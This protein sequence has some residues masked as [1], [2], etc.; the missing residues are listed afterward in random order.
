MAKKLTLDD[1]KIQSFVTTLTK[2][3]SDDLIGGSTLHS[4]CC[5]VSPACTGDTSFNNTNCCDTSADQCTTNYTVYGS[6]YPEC[7]GCGS[8]IPSDC[9]CGPTELCT[10]SND[11]CPP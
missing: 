11:G 7:S 9:G 10:I 8:A 6:T 4:D 2:P 5:S 3:Q 1:L